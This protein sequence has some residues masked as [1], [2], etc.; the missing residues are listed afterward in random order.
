MWSARELLDS[1]QISCFYFNYRIN[2]N[3]AC[4]KDLGSIGTSNIGYMIWSLTL[5]ALL[6]KIQSVASP[7]VL[8]IHTRSS[9]MPTFSNHE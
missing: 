5:K 8:F 4:T 7:S 6:H 3:E 1:N 9:R 2:R